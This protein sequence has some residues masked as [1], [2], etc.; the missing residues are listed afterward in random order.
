MAKTV[1]EF[2]PQRLYALAKAGGPIY[3]W[4][5][6]VCMR[7]DART[8][9]KLSNDM[10]KVRTGNLRSSQAPP[11]LSTPGT[12]IVAIIQNTASYALMVHNGTRPHEILPRSK[13]A[14]YFQ[15]NGAPVFAR[16]VHHPGTSAR[17]FL[18]DS[19]VE[20]FASL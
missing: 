3:R 1:V 9:Q 19:L 17:P 11:I 15:M 7:V 16:R 10:V 12:R 6:V 13:R 5:F 20:V 14:L 4:V 18:R 2:Y 8:K